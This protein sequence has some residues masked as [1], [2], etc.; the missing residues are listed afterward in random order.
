MQLRGHDMKRPHFVVAFC[1]C[2]PQRNVQ[3]W[4]SRS[5]SKSTW[6]MRLQRNFRWSISTT[7][8]N[9]NRRDH[10]SEANRADAAAR[11][12]TE[13]AV[14]STLETFDVAFADDPLK[15]DYLDSRRKST[16]PSI[17]PQRLRARSMLA[18]MHVQP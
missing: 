10:A 17:R 4:Q 2:L 3:R 6:S 16:R 14:L 9:R 12:E 18:Q 11:V 15:D 8:S 1:P 7:S 13:E 5:K